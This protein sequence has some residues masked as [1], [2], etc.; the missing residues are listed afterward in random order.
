MELELQYLYRGE[1][2]P[3]VPTELA[4]LTLAGSETFTITDTY[5]D[6]E[7]LELRRAHCSLRV[8]TAENRASSHLTW[9]GPPKR[10][11]RKG[12]KR[13]EVELPISSIPDTD[14]DLTR[15]LRK[16]GLWEVIRDAA[17]LP[18]PFCLNPIGQLH[19]ERST[20]TY[21]QGLHVLELCWDRIEYPIGSPELRVEVEVKSRVTEPYLE[22]ADA[23]LRELFGSDL[24]KPKRGKVQELCTRLYPDVLAAA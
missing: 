12:K 7:D 17:D 23:A 11:R 18:D 9:K 3:I 19:N 16:H 10:R 1:R 6:T 14:G 22:Q 13:T 21:A 4:H 2:Q 20:H 24:T 8:R 5:F 15:L